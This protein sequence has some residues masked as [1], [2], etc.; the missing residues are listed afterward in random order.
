MVTPLR[1]PFPACSITSKSLVTSSPPG[2]VLS[3]LATSCI[4]LATSPRLAKSSPL[5]TLWSLYHRRLKLTNFL[6]SLSSSL[7]VMHKLR[8]K[9]M[10][11]FPCDINQDRDTATAETKR[12]RW[13][14]EPDTFF[15]SRVSVMGVLRAP[16]TSLGPS[17]NYSSC[18]DVAQLYSM[19]LHSGDM[20][21]IRDRAPVICRGFL[22][23]NLIS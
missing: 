13:W 14:R 10:F 12:G 1:C 16:L 9:S 2:L 22:I 18:R 15:V 5:A 21:R 4:T 23:F 19:R 11:I 7:I 8:F 6:G 3:R 20:A 17:I